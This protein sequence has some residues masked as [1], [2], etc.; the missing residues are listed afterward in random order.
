M[1]SQSC[2]LQFGWIEPRLHS[3]DSSFFCCWAAVV[4]SSLFLQGRGARREKGARG[5]KGTR[6]REAEGSEKG[7]AVE[8]GKGSIEGEGGEEG[9]GVARAPEAAEGGRAE[10]EGGRHE[11]TGRVGGGA[12]AGRADAGRGGGGGG[13]KRGGTVTPEAAADRGALFS[14][15][16]LTGIDDE[17]MRAKASC[18]HSPLTQPGTGHPRRA[19]TI[20]EPL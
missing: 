18:P 11:Q 16:T 12:E 4:D 6:E 3:Q 2:R 15:R 7:N 9:R 19:R 10:G 13:E 14:E 17:K 5:E 1:F 8:R 20:V